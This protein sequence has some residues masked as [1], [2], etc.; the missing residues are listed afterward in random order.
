LKLA[1][2]IKHSRKKKG[3]SQAELAEKIGSHLSHVT[4]M[5]TGKYNPSVDVLVKLADALEVSVDQLL[6]ENGKAGEVH[7]EDQTFAERLRLIN[8]FSKKEKEAIITF[9]D[10]IATKKKLL[11]LIKDT[12]SA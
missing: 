8:S 11:N 10:A 9:I 7:Y 12:E 3:W 1:E 2:N 5:E 6:S 4:R